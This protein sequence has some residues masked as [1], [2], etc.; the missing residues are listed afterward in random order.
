MP[1][2]ESNDLH[3]VTGAFG[4]SGRYM[5]RRLLDAGHRVRTLTNSP[6]R[7][8]PFGGKVEVR[9]Y[10]FDDPDRL[11]N[12]L[13]GVARTRCVWMIRTTVPT[14]YSMSG[15]ASSTFSRWATAMRR[16]SPSRAAWTASTVPGRP[17]EIGTATPGYTT[18]SL[19]GRTGRVKRS[20][21]IP[22][23]R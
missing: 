15:V 18:V 10:D 9:P 14:L 8:N 22:R 2:L 11:V 23:D 19:S 20:P 17:A 1:G 4:Y 13:R 6:W 3:V 5:A 12:S 21:M 7:E 16:L